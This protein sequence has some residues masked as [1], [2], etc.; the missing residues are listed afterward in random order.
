MKIFLE[1]FVDANFGD[2]LFVQTIVKRYPQHVFY[3]ETKEKHEKSYR[4]LTE[5]YDNIR[6]FSNETKK[7]VI[8][9]MD[10]MFVVGGDMFWNEGDYS[11]LL[12][13]MDVI[14]KKR[15]FIAVLGLSLFEEYSRKT[16]NDLRILF[17]YADMIVARERRTYDQI[18]KMAPWVKVKEASDMAFTVDV[19]E[20]E[21][22]APEKGTLGISIRKK[23][24]RNTPDAYET[25]CDSMAKVVQGYLEQEESHKV[26]FL[27]MSTGVYDDARVAADIRN[28]CA[29]SYRERM[30][31]INFE[32]NVELY[33]KEIQACEKL[34]CT[35]FH[36]LVFAILLKKTFIPI[37][38]EEKTNRLLAAIGYQGL[39]QRYEDEMNEK[40]MLD[41]LKKDFV[42]TEPMRQYL[43]Q[44]I[45]FFD[46]VDAYLLNRK[47]R[48]KR[49]TVIWTGTVIYILK[50]FQTLYEMSRKILK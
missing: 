6:L 49:T 37:V 4:M 50:V 20:I 9:D 45:H 16:Q 22:I 32:G 26:R 25:Y 11:S 12:D 13:S 19:S 46:E 44:A 35:R 30:E 23:I 2:N 15:G 47:I 7:K 38:Y 40:I 14:R 1:A 41:E 21:K 29:S 3:M 10:A 31:C 5:Q 34:I 36:A 8:Q 39:C 28:K 27:A 17:T 33:M 18:K 42:S 43:K 48:K 24:P